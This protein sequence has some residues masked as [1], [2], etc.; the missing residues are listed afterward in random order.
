MIFLNA[1]DRV[2]IE[3]NA[4]FFE[5]KKGTK[6][7]QNFLKLTNNLFLLKIMKN[8]IYTI[9]ENE[10]GEIILDNLTQKDLIANKKINKSILKNI[11][12]DKSINK[13]D[14]IG[15]I[16]GYLFATK[17]CNK[18]F[19]IKIHNIYKDA[20]EFRKIKTQELESLCYYLDKIENITSEFSYC[21]KDLNNKPIHN[22]GDLFNAIELTNKNRQQKLKDFIIKY[23]L[24]AVN[25]VVV[26]RDEQTRF[27]LNPFLLKNSDCANDYLIDMFKM[28][29]KKNININ[30]FVIDLLK[31]KYE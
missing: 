17:E 30:E 31:L 18:Y 12:N 24:I 5:T 19:Q 29:L 25:K 28:F 4:Y 16:W 21:I 23:K 14:K 6:L 26:G 13:E 22:W 27:Y 1:L 10:T 7:Y 11:L 9:L 20:N 8:K 2:S 15:A 3:Q